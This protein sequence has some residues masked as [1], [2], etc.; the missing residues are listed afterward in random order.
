MEPS[1]SLVFLGVIEEE[2]GVLSFFNADHPLVVLY[3]D[4]KS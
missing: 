3:R 4:E 1:S 2:T